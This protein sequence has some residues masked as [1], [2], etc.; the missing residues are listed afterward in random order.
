MQNRVLDAADILIHRQPII[1]ALIDHGLI[2]IRARKAQVIPRRIDEGVHG[3]RLAPRRLVAFR[4]F[5]IEKRRR[6]Q[7]WIAA[8]VGYQIIRQLHRQLIVRYRHRPAGIAVN[9]RYGTA[10][11]ALPRDAPIA[12]SIRRAQ[13][14][15]LQR[16]QHH[17]HFVFRFFSRAAV[18]IVGIETDAVID[19]RFFQRQC[20][21]AI[22][23]FD[24]RFDRQAILGRKF[25]VAFV[26]S[27]H[28]HHRAF[29]VT[30]Q[31]IV[32]RPHRER[33][34]RQRVIHEQ[35]R[36]HA[37]FFLRRQFRFSHATAFAF[38]D[39]CRQR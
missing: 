28:G 11:I 15:E 39:E 10:P 24:Y 21:L 30:H 22:F 26:V 33:L 7:Q 18:E 1:D 19:E 2:V 9:D 4:T 16:L 8:A 6:F 35:A 34:I 25:E 36:V 38:F 5:G 14:A 37:L 3:V 27:R 32:R 29:A 13:V 23:G 12:Q 31:H 20:Q 17:A